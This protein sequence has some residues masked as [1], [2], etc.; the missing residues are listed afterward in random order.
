V[1]IAPDWLLSAR[2]CAEAGS[3]L[4]V[5]LDAAGGLARAL[6]LHSHPELDLALVKLEPGSLPVEPIPASSD[7]AGPALL[8]SPAQIAGHGAGSPDGAA[9]FLAVTIDEIGAH[10]I[11]VNAGGLGGACL[12]DSGG[13]LLVRGA[14]GAIRVAGIL[15]A[16][17]ATCRGQDHYTRV[18]AATSL[19]ESRIG[20]PVTPATPCGSLD[21]AGRCY[22]ERAVWCENGSTRAQDCAAPLGC[23]WDANFAGFRCVEPASDP[24]AG[25]D[26][27]GQCDGDV[28][29]RCEGGVLRH[30]SCAS[31]GTSCSRAPSSGRA[32]CN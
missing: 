18:D 30:T 14:D 31:C 2:H 1:V 32:A 22:G 27:L 21:G 24:C 28:A 25:V 5:R 29:V 26:D 15:R 23:G 9:G 19:L 13:P 7:P 16:G 4:G 11:S 3:I 6:E 12:G 17:S 8:G 20:P 10:E